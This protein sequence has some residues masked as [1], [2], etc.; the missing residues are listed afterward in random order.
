MEVRRAIFPIYPLSGAALPSFK[1]EDHR[2]YM[3]NPSHAL[4]V[5]RPESLDRGTFG[6]LFSCILTLFI[7]VYTVLHLN[8]S[9]GVSRVS[10]SLQK[11]L[12]A[13]VG[14]FA[15]ELIVYIAWR[16]WQSAKE[17]TREINL[18][19]DRQVILC[20]DGGIQCLTCTESEAN[21]TLESETCL[22]HDT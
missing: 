4:I 14:I 2:I 18:I 6:L 9:P 22:D 16:Q 12:W 20:F 13:L 10:L 19:L 17:L 21:R 7:C 8:V 11:F 15:P 3:R 1:E 5:H